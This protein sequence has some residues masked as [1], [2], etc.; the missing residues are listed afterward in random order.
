MRFSGLLLFS[1]IISSADAWYCQCGSYCPNSTTPWL[2]PVKC[3]AGS[4]CPTG[5]AYKTSYPVAC[6]A[7][8]YCPAQ[9]CTPG[10]CPCGYYCPKGSSAI[11][12]CHAGYYC[13]ANSSSP[14]KNPPGHFSYSRNC[15]S[16]PCPCGYKCPVGSTAPIASQPP[17]YIPNTVAINQ[18]LCP[19]GY[20]CD[21]PLGAREY[22]S[23]MLDLR[24][25][26]PAHRERIPLQESSLFAIAIQSPPLLS[27][28]FPL[29][30]PKQLGDGH[31]QCNVSGM[32][33]GGGG[34]GGDCGGRGAVGSGVMRWEPRLRSGKRRLRS[35][36][37]SVRSGQRSLR[38]GRQRWCW[39]PLRFR[40]ITGYHP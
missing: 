18:T 19:I 3:P 40:R 31:R 20:K 7:G 30:S 16:S 5:L 35:G 14:T 6:P 32:A 33:R 22:S 39:S 29:R 37:R 27:L 21:K 28:K 38:S 23:A 2:E 4:Y 13:P 34:G 1:V 10:P 9:S 12:P 8:K 15:S 17:F 36:Q 11:I 25:P 26:S 24:R